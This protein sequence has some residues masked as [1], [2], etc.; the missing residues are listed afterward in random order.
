LGQAV[1][2][3]HALYRGQ[4]EKALDLVIERGLSANFWQKDI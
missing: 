3:L 2:P 1:S 4:A